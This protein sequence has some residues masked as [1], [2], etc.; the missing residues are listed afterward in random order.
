MAY[1][2]LWSPNF[3]APVP[4][5]DYV[6][7]DVAARI[8]R[9]GAQD[10]LY[11]FPYQ[12]EFEHDPAR[13]PVTLSPHTMAIY[14]YPT[15]F[16]WFCLPFSYLPFRAGASAWALFMSGCLIAALR[17]LLQTTT[18]G[19][20]AFG[21]ALLAAV[22]F[23]PTLMSIYSCQN[24]TLSLLILAVTYALLR[25]G[26]AMTAGCV[27]ALQAFKPQL[28]LVI[29]GAMLYKRQWRFVLGGL[30]GGLGL[31]L[32]SLVI[33]P[34]A[35]ADYLTLGPT[36]ARWIDMPG[37]PLEGMACWQGFWRLLIG[38]RPLAHVRAATVASS[39]L[40]L[41][42]LAR[43]LI[44]PLNTASERFPS[45]F[46]ALVLG[47]I[48]ISPHLLYY[49]MTLLLIPMILA[50]CSGPV[51]MGTQ[52]NDIVWPWSTAI[53]FAGATV[54]RSVAAD[55]G[56]QIIVPMILIYLIVLVESRCRMPT[57]PGRGPRNSQAPRLKPDSPLG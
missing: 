33:S 19:R 46:A 16:A 30:L 25:Q 24:A 45:Q 12:V 35:T 49:D 54:S 13:M 39:L 9:A 48:L 4:G 14:I 5:G 10:R 31:L 2:L 51:A 37:M 21:Y 56:F 40:T 1:I 7:F 50:A 32:A 36:M 29:A 55:T 52:T 44:G 17:V 47:T 57:P 18:R 27:F 3:N 28:T 20:G 11:D 41:I 23:L 6:Q 43:G 8:V 26:R 22:P 53:L 15:F 42:P 38:H 34:K